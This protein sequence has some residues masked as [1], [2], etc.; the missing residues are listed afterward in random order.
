MPPSGRPDHSLRQRRHNER[1]QPDS[2]RSQSERKSPAIVEPSRRQPEARFPIPP[3]P[4]SRKNRAS[5]SSL[6]SQSTTYTNIGVDW[7]AARPQPSF[8]LRRKRRSSD[9]NQMLIRA[10]ENLAPGGSRRRE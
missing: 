6:L 7:S 5:P 9:R 2:G 1:S 8:C 3:P 4:T 10:Q